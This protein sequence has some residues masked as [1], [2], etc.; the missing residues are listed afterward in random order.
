MT[1]RT[2]AHQ[3]LI[4]WD[5]PSRNTGGL[6]FSSPGDLPNPG[7]EPV[8]PALAG[9]CFTTAPHGKPFRVLYPYFFVIFYFFTLQYCI[10]SA[11]HQHESTIGILSLFKNNEI[12]SFATTWIDL[13]GIMLSEIRERKILHVIIYMWKIKNKLVNIIKK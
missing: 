4:S 2:V 8:S 13:E 6:P 7:I 10:G 1:L 12:L 9:R 11:T 5:F 3:V